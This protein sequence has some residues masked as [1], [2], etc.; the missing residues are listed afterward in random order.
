MVYP[1]KRNGERGH[2]V[3][4]AAPILGAIDGI[5]GGAFYDSYWLMRCA[6]RFRGSP[7]FRVRGIDFR[8]AMRP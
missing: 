8:A 6:S 7:Y 3:L 4:R 1:A 5:R 2:V